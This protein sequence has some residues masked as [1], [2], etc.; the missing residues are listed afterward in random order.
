[1]NDIK[2]LTHDDGSYMSACCSA[3]LA[4]V[5]HIGNDIVGT[6]TDCKEPASPAVCEYCEGTGIYES[7]T[8]DDIKEQV[9]VCRAIS[10][11]ELLKRG[12]EEAKAAREVE[13]AAR[14]MG[15]TS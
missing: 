5:S 4:L 11:D 7:R 6:C 1:M 2:Y 3:H 15:F 8:E 12:G 9:C 10:P 13:A 14:D